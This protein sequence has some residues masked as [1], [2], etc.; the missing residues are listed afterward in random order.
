MWR[1]LRLFLGQPRAETDEGSS[2][3]SS[4]DDVPVRP[5]HTRHGFQHSVSRQ[6]I[7]YNPPA[8]P[9]PTEWDVPSERSLQREAQQARHTEIQCVLAHQGLPPELIQSICWEANEGLLC[10]VSRDELA[11]YSDN[12]NEVYLTTPT[13]TSSLV[14]DFCL[15]ITV[16]TWSHDQ[17]WSSDPHRDWL[18]TYQGSYTWWELTLDRP[19][20]SS[21]ETG[22]DA[23]Q[24]H[25]D[26]V[27]R[28][29][30]CHNI[31]ASSEFT[32]HKLTLQRDHPLLR[33]IQQSDRLS[34][35]ARTQYPG[36]TNIV[37]SARIQVRFCWS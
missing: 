27:H 32:H 26:E 7:L 5:M 18:G 6:H 12:A 15:E 34:L 23:S 37:R 1:W 21:S 2:S 31:H 19:T 13:L 24:P 14:R 20:P 16:D 4:D 36:W 22:N 11:M 25:T 33:D 8:P 10:S 17:G 35:W 3:S 30:V 28:I 9:V 29:H